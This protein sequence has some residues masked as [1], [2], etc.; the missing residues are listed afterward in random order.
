MPNEQWTKDYHTY[1]DPKASDS[2]HMSARQTREVHDDAVAY[3]N[4]QQ[5]KRREKRG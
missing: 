4:E 1:Y 3:A 2:Q 5:R